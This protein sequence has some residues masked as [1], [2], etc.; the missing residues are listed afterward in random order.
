MVERFIR[1]I[2][3]P[4][5]ITALSFVALIALV[6][7][8]LLLPVSIAAGKTVSFVDA[9]FVATSAVCVVGLT[10]IDI[11]TDFSNTGQ[12]VLMIAMQIGALGLMTFTTVFYAAIGKRL[13]LAHNFII[14]QSFHHS[15]TQQIRQLLLYIVGYTF[16]TEIIGAVLYFVYWTAT[17]RFSSAGETLWHSVFM[18]VTAFTNGGFS[19]YSNSI[20]GFQQDK[21]IMMVTAFLILAGG[22]GF[23][24]SFELKNFF[25]RGLRH[26]EG[27]RGIRLSV[28]TKITLLA[29]LVITILAAALLYIAERSAAFAHLGFSDGLLNAFFYT[30]T[31]RSGGL[32]S[33]EMISF[34]G[35]SILLI[36]VMMFIGA[37][38]GSTGGGI[39]AGT[40]GLIAAYIYARLRGLPQLSLWGRTIPKESIDKAIGVAAVVGLFVVV[41]S[42]VLMYTE[43]HTISSYESRVVFVQV[44]FE[45]I[46]AACTVGL[47]LDFT[48]ELSE[49]GKAF[50]SVVMLVGRLSPIGLAIAITAKHKKARYKFSEENI[51]IG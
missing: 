43:T 10:P 15:P 6:T 9:V 46:S 48:S 27:E 13:P 32:Q 23:L 16:A 39:K 21:F 47:S 51:I 29:T 14:Q 38:A 19:L 3:T 37:G 42:L 34:H 26:K 31:P 28:H 35:S 49:I 12:I 1:R 30:V 24:V 8:F 20:V 11:S 44:V 40:I 18:S 2:S 5:R 50:L 17:G 45:A 22:I 36:M 7:I 25:T 4:A 41:T 33:M